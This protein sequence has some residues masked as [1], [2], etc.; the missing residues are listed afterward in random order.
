MLSRLSIR[1]RL[2]A[3]FAAAMILVLALAG[4]FVYVKVR[5]DLNEALEESLGSRAD[6]VAAL[7]SAA[8]SGTPDLGGERLVD[9]EDS[10]A[11][12]LGPGGEVVASTLPSDAGAVISPSE[13]ERAD[14]GTVF[15]ERDVPGIDGGAKLLARSVTTPS[16]EATVVV[17]AT[18]QDR[19]E[20]LAGLTGAFAIGTPVAILLTSLLGY[21]VAGRALAP[22][23]AMRRR[24]AGITLERSGERLPLPAA[25]DELHRLGETLNE[26]LDRIEVSLERERV[27]VAD[28][29]HELRT[30]LAI[31]RTELELARRPGRSPEELRAALQSTAEE[32]D[33]LARLAEDL[34]V[35]ARSDQGRLPIKREPVELAHLL[36][37]VRDRFAARAAE[38]GRELTVSAPE[39]TRRDLD[40]M[41]IE[42]A[43]GN[44]VD[45]ALRHGA[46]E[47]RLA[48]RANGDSTLLEVSDDGDGFP[49]AFGDQAFERFS[50]A[51]EGRT[52]GGAGLGLAI[53]RAVARAHGGDA[54]LDGTAIR[55]TIPS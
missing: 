35:I 25:D 30:P 8:G 36:E 37:R 11:Q 1:A 54:A 19:S 49:A 26:M 10:F 50:R 45:N 14:T 28:A 47:V 24:A 34:L 13:A 55:L 32:V 23:E 17:G 39:G 27:F 20:A 31:L 46:G 33:R 7:V 6:D 41:R 29:S 22:V 16:G 51:D 48:A 40:P 15:S 53:V 52:G 38:D 3:A 12:V 21:L 43:L 9:G 44:L 2:T 42:Q 4:L 18:T 5:S